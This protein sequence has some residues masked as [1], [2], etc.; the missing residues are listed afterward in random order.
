MKIYN[1]Y[2]DSWQHEQQYYYTSEHRHKKQWYGPC[3]ECGNRTTDC[4]GSIVCIDDYCKHSSN[5]QCV[6]PIKPEPSW[7]NSDINVQKDGDM[8]CAFRDGFINLQESEAAFGD[9]PEQAV[10]YLKQK[11]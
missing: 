1:T 7:W 3:P 10:Q 9:T 2:V 4:G 6:S 8:W 5:R 11:G